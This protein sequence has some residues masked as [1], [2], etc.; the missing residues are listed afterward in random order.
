MCL[1]TIIYWVFLMI[2]L[3]L[4]IALKLKANAIGQH[5]TIIMVRKD[6]QDGSQGRIR[7]LVFELLRFMK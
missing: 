3:S 4:W 6:H 5:H 2:L 1:Q 7:H